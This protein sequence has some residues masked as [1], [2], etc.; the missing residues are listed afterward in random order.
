MSYGLA[1]VTTS[2]GA[3]GIGLTDGE[4]VLI[5]DDAEAFVESIA[6]IYNDKRLWEKISKNG[7]RYVEKNFSQGIFRDSV[8]DMMDM[9]FTTVRGRG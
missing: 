2:V 7:Q 5:A 3:E 8:R 6:R 4:N 1:V 9:L